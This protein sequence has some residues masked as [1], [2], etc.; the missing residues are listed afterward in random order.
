M[1]TYNALISFDAKDEDDLLRKLSK[2]KNH[3]LEW[4]QEVGINEEYLRLKIKKEEANA[5]KQQQ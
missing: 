2:I 1:K 4:W 3:E 5:R